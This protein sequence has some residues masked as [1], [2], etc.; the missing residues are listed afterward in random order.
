VAARQL[1]HVGAG[2]QAEPAEQAAHR[3]ARAEQP[4]AGQQRQHDL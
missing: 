2:V 1:G 3:A 4:G